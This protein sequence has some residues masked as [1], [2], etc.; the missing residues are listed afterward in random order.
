M[1]HWF[2][3]YPDIGFLYNRNNM[4]YGF[5]SVPEDVCHGTGV[6]ETDVIDQIIQNPVA[7]ETDAPILLSPKNEAFFEYN[8]LA[9]SI[10]YRVNYGIREA[11]GSVE[12]GAVL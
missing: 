11:G 3:L 9:H 10:R 12:I 2:A 6:S 5:F 1:E 8:V 7:K 4:Y